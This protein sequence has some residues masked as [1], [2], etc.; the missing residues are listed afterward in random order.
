VDAKLKLTYDQVGDILSIDVCE[1][2][3]GQETE[4]IDTGMV[5]RFNPKTGAV[6]NLEI[7]FWSKRLERGEAVV[8]PLEA[9]IRLAVEA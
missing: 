2:Y 7:M 3:V 5:A 4:E 6:E 1:P 9:R 8:L